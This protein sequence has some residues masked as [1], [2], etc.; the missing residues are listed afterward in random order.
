MFDV[1]NAAVLISGAPVVF[2]PEEHF[3]FLVCR[4]GSEVVWRHG[5][6]RI[7]PTRHSR[8]SSLDQ[9]K[10][11]LLSDGT[12]YIRELEE[13]DSG[14]YYC[15]DQL[16]AELTV[17]TGSDYV[18]SEGSTLYLPC[19]FSAK[20]KQRWSYKHTWDSRREFISTLYKN[21]SVLQER[22]DP[23]SRFIHNYNHLHI[24]NLQPSDSGI[25]LCNGH[26]IASVIIRPAVIDVYQTATTESTD[27]GKNNPHLPEKGVLVIF[28]AFSVLLVVVVTLLLVTL[29]LKFGN[30][31][32]NT[33]PK[34][35]ETEL[36]LQKSS[37]G[38]RDRSSSNEEHLVS[39]KDHSEVQ[40]ASLGRHNF[41]PRGWTR[42][43]RQQVIYSTLMLTPTSS[44][45]N[46]SIT[47]RL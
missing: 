34:P 36:Q 46:T 35:E 7:N 3:L 23:D 21:G 8:S 10:H 16:V 17:L 41:R 13:S 25:Y 37:G 32:K 20:P 47:P 19:S 18:V 26:T 43:S 30:R 42:D 15:N 39:A 40:Y 9:T 29:C 12:L 33:E 2:V 4:R 22:S 27:V 28:L 14:R 44:P 5:S 38:D 24:I 45:T 31:R 11:Q 1:F 6:V